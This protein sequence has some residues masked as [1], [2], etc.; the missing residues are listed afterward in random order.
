L[1]GQY[2]VFLTDFSDNVV[3]FKGFVHTMWWPFKGF[4]Q[5]MW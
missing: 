1:S 4:V 3:V 5:T 2:G